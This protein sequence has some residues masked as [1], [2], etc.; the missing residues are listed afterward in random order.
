MKA[1]RNEQL[2][3]LNVVPQNKLAEMAHVGGN[4]MT[5][6]PS[7]CALWPTPPAGAEF[8]YEVALVRRK[9]VAA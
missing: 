1:E 3:T 5:G 8:D 6:M 9:K 4:A 7:I 2:F